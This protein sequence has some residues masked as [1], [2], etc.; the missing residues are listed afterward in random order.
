M[1][2]TPQARVDLKEKLRS[3]MQDLDGVYPADKHP[4]APPAGQLRRA[5]PHKLSST[6]RLMSLVEIDGVLFWQDGSGHSLSGDGLRRGFRGPARRGEIIDRVRIN[7]LEPN[8]IGEYLEQLDRKLT[9]DQGLR[10]WDAGGLRPLVGPPAASGKILLLLHGTFSKSEMYVVELQA[11]PEG[12]EFLAR[13]QAHYTQILVFDHPTLAVS[14]FLNALDLS[15]L[16]EGSLADIDVIAHSRG[17]LVARWWLGS[18]DRALAGN[19]RAVL[20][21]APLEGTSLASPPRIRSLLSWF[22][23]LNQVLSAGASAGSAV[24]PFLTV[25]SGLLRVAAAVTNVAAR[26]PLADSALAMVPGLAGQSRV[27]NNFE[28]QR[29]NSG[30]LGAPEYFAIR[31]NFTTTDEGWKF[32]KYFADPAARALN[33][34]ADLLFGEKNDLVVDTAS[35]THRVIADDDHLYDFRDSTVVHHV[36]YFRQPETIAFL[37]KKLGLD[38]PVAPPS[39]PA[40][41]RISRAGAGKAGRSS[42]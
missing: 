39:A 21:G 22:T 30:V 36:N 14:P 20:V 28:L 29:L 40:P 6:T 25:V 13:A 33:A 10:V 15:R 16:L 7:Q 8:K 24:L 17:G 2:P 38:Q 26:S 41:R 34:G 1:T 37:T 12:R 19:R 18:F 27:S 3:S 23:N 42:R 9:P 32:W 4:D 35:M 5:R 31:S 11:T